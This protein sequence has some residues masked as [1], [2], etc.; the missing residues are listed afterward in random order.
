MEKI[1]VILDC[2]TGIDDALAILLALRSEKINL[3]GICACAGNTVLKNAYINSKRMVKL[4]DREDIPVI[5]GSRG[6]LVRSLELADE[7]HGSDGFGGIG[8]SF[9]QKY[10]FDLAKAEAEYEKALIEDDVVEFVKDTVEKYE[11]VVLVTIG[12]MTNLAKTLKK[13]PESF[14]KLNRIVSMGGSYKRGG[15]V[16]EH[17]EFNYWVDPDAADYVYKNSPVKVEMVGLDVTHQILLTRER[18]EKLKQLNPHLGGFIEEITDFYFG[19]YM[20]KNGIAGC[21]MHDPLTFAHIIDDDILSGEAICIGIDTSDEK[22]GKSFKE[23]GKENSLVFIDADEDRFFEVL[24][25][26]IRK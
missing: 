13:Y 1:N 3:V 6:P 26:A 15:N 16:T 21:V 22:R 14:A 10:G 11:D 20:E 18:L 7:V 9:D 25:K 17:A 23:D 5:C 24:N 8:E 2:D 19:F 4:L 12:P